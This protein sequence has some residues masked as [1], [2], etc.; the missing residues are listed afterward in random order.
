[1]SKR[2]NRVLI[3]RSAIAVARSVVECCWAGDG[4]ATFRSAT[5]RYSDK[6]D[7][8]AAWHLIYIPFRVRMS[9]LHLIERYR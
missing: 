6:C 3:T 8:D 1:M 7:E 9:T 5:R 4:R 2:Q